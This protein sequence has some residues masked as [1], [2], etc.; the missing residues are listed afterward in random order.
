LRLRPI[1]LALCALLFEEGNLPNQDQASNVRS[2]K[3]L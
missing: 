2:S 1:G 3:T